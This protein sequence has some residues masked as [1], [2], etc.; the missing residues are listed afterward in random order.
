[1]TLSKTARSE[2]ASDEFWQELPKIIEK[3]EKEKRKSQ[4]QKEKVDN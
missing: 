4:G 1:M 2:Y 3:L